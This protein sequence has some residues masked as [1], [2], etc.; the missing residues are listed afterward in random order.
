VLKHLLYDFIKG[1]YVFQTVGPCVTVFGSARLKP[2]T[3]AYDVA[4]RIGKSL[5]S[6]G[7]TVMTGGGPGLMEAV[8]RG[9]R[10]VGGRAAACGVN[11]GFE[12][13]LGAAADWRVTVRYMFV[14][15]VLLCRYS[16]AFVV[17]PGGFGT[18]DEL[19]EVLTL[20][21]TKKI[22]PIPVVLIGTAYWRPLVT[23]L[24]GMV[25]AETIRAA[26]LEQIR[27]TDDPDD[28]VAHI[29]AQATPA[30][31]LHR[32]TPPWS[33]PQTSSWRDV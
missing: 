9:A 10:D 20:V 3:A 27:V 8:T 5:S 19:F 23:A 11:F 25:Q 32:R 13:G 7:L 14:R 4:Y 1:M 29:K 26:D 28:V 6:L 18:L 2:H 21:Q 17:L 16:C 30:F 12:Q 33:V 24:E 22:A 31:Q 15:K